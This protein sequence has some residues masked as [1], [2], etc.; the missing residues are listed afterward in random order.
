MTVRILARAAAILLAIA[1]IVDPVWT[2][3]IAV[4]PA[5]DVVMASTPSER[6]AEWRAA[7]DRRLAGRVSF[8]ASSAAAARVLVGRGVWRNSWE[9]PDVPT[10]TVLAGADD[11]PGVR[12]VAAR[13]AAPVPLGW[14][15]T[16]GVTLEARGLAGNATQIVLEHHGVEI[17]RAQQAWTR[18]PERAAIAIPYAFAAEGISRVTLRALP[19]EGERDTSDNTVDLRAVVRAEPLAILV[20]EPR[21]SWSA[22]FVR[23]G[24]ER[25][26]TFD[27]SAQAS[28]SRGLAV[29]AGRPP[30][31]LTMATL[32]RFDA[33]VI[34]APDELTAA[35]V[36]ELGDFARHRGGAIV[37][38]PDRRPAGPYLSLVPAD[39]FDELLVAKP[40]PAGS[41][42]QTWLHATELALPRV[43]QSGAEALASVQ[44]ERGAQP[45]VVTWPVGAG[46]VIFSGALDAWRFRARD[47]DAFTRFWELRIAEAALAAPPPLELSLDPPIASP[48]EEVV[49]RARVRTTQ[50]DRAA[51]RTTVPP[52]A[53]RLTGRDGSTRTLR[54]WPGGDV[55]GF[56]GRAVLDAPGAFVVEATSGSL[57]AHD[58]LTVVAGARRPFPSDT[59]ARDVG[60]VLATATGGLVADATDPGPLENRLASLPRATTEERV[61]PTRSIWFVALFVVLLSIDWTLRR[62]RGLA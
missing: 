11:S 49:I 38:L 20:Y 52:I 40:L 54:L 37:L 22:T 3:T 48:G 33:V 56:E 6:E 19:Y 55:G 2:R 62:R 9:S 16:F 50:L 21:P 51:D 5:V 39:S 24:L 14:T 60:R 13:D 1:G 15:S 34:G 4:P 42:G 18:S 31:R 29:T 32:A 46:R 27:L 36:T 57:V 47:E 8:E 61:H 35:E 28:L 10:S 23:R 12:I 43:G 45:L 17:A 7:L 58:V 25:S 59:D 41:A 44:L 53:V 26:A 30:A